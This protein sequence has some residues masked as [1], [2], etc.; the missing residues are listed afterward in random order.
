M[1]DLFILVV[2]RRFAMAND[3]FLLNLSPEL[4][5]GGHHEEILDKDSSFTS[6]RIRALT[7]EVSQ[8]YQSL[9]FTAIV[10]YLCL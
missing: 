6:H 7:N 4:F 10:Y 9:G 3:G 8:D 5:D 2:F 1:S